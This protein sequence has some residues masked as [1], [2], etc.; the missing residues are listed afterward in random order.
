MED[1]SIRKE[2]SRINTY[3]YSFNQDD[4]EESLYISMIVILALFIVYIIEII[5]IFIDIYRSIYKYNIIRIKFQ[6]FYT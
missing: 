3:D 1:I 5:Q 6:Y 4:N 2:E